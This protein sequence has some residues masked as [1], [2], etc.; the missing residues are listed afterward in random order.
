M[1]FF[2]IVFGLGGLAWEPGSIKYC[3]A[4]KRE[5]QGYVFN[6]VL[7]E[8]GA[9]MTSFSAMTNLSKRNMCQDKVDVQ[10]R[11]SQEGRQVRREERER[12]V[13]EAVRV[14]VVLQL[15][16]PVSLRL[17]FPAE[18]IIFNPGN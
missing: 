11:G 4:I 10:G 12:A 6:P 9:E 3:I 14:A 18:C 13:A 7:Q 15:P 17:N 5:I 16:N 2:P 8:D 1:H